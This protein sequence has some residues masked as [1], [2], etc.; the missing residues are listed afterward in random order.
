MYFGE[1]TQA[2]TAAL[3]LFVAVEAMYLFSCRSLT[4]SVWRIGLFGNPWLIA[5]VVSQMLAQLAITYLPAMN[6]VFQTAPIGPGAWLRIVAIAAGI[7]LVVGFEKWLRT[8]A[9]RGSAAVKEHDPV[10]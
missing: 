5:G 10:V 6:T 9:F 2:R 8:L 4:R 7:S 1:S 3:N